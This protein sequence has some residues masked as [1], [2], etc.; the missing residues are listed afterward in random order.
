MEELSTSEHEAM[1]FGSKA[2]ETA[3]VGI[4]VSRHGEDCPGSWD[5]NCLSALG[6]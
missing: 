6:G 3:E 2:D 1:H 4:A 5:T